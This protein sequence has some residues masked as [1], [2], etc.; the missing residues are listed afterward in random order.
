MPTASFGRD[1]QQAPTFTSAITRL[2]WTLKDFGDGSPSLTLNLTR[3]GNDWTQYYSAGKANGA[4]PSADGSKLT[5][6][7]EWKFNSG[8]Q[9]ARMLNTLMDACDAANRLYLTDD[10]KSFNGTEC[11][12]VNEPTPTKKNPNKTI[13]VVKAI[14][15]ASTVPTV[16]TEQDDS[17]TAKMVLQA[18]LDEQE[19]VNLEDID[20]KGLK[21]YTN[22]KDYASRKKLADV[23]ADPDYVSSLGYNVNGSI[24]TQ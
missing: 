17:A 18:M 10:L 19:E 21:K 16:P 1:N 22:G 6:P 15:T 4:K 9:A 7:P 5:T 23:L 3:K 12:W 2:W 13:P 8:C 20:A 11:E 14:S 24:V